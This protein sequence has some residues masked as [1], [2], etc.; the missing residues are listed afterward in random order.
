M[1]IILTECD[2]NIYLDID[3]VLLGKEHGQ[4][5]LASGVYEFL[6]KAL[7]EYK[8]FWLTTHCKGDSSTALK[9]MK[10]YCDEK[11]FKLIEKIQPSNFNVLKT[12]AIDFD[13]E[14]LWFDD[15]LL[16]SEIEVLHRK[17]RLSSWI[18]IDTYK[19][20]YDLRA[21]KF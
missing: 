12:D 3:G 19:N 10:K 1:Q 5:K 14:F 6:W 15:F 11:T 16:Q 18:Q 20:F 7:T 8:C 4:V 9:Y 21:F 17:E 2:I 13:S